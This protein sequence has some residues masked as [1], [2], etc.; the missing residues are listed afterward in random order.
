M[1]I[2]AAAIFDPNNVMCALP[3]ATVGYCIG[4]SDTSLGLLHIRLP[5]LKPFIPFS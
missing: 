1:E 4:I 2:R 3:G 5:V